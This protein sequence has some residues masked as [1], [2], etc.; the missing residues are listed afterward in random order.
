MHISL[1]LC[2]AAV[3]GLNTTTTANI[4]S[5]TPA[6]KDW[7]A[8]MGVIFGLVLIAGYVANNYRKGHI[9]WGKKE[10]TEKSEKDGESVVYLPY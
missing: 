1:E 9:K 10:T 3:D 6:Q 4:S 5:P 8:A 7:L 2:E